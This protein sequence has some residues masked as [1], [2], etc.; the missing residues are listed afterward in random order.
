MSQGGQLRGLG[1]QY[2]GPWMP[3]PLCTETAA[4]A[5]RKVMVSHPSKPSGEDHLVLSAAP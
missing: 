3:G 1:C 4:K 5:Q 2:G